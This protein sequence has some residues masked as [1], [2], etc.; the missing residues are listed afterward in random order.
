[1]SLALK[2]QN[3]PSRKNQVNIAIIKWQKIVIIGSGFGGLASAIRM[4]KGY[5]ATLVEKHPDLGGR[6]RVFKKEILRMTVV[7]L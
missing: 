1:M 4:S 7:Q 3:W 2:K 6:A 5:D